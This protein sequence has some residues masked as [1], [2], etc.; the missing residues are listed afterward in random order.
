[1]AEKLP[2]TNQRV[3][4]HTA[5]EVN[6]RIRQQSEANVAS[7][8]GASREVISDRL[9]AIEREWDMERT[10]EANAATVVL[11]GTALGFAINKKW[12]AF[13]GLAAAFLLQHALQ[14]WCPPVPFWRRRGVR[15]Q[16]EIFEEKMALK[17]LRGD[18]EPTA[19]PQ[20]ALAQ[21][22]RP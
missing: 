2:E 22:R 9:R 6:E 7:C 21:A 13:S 15:T 17:V 1:L 12:F 19:D 20:E 16:R 10:L 3:E 8:A 11:L 18:F 14:G 5:P 4:L